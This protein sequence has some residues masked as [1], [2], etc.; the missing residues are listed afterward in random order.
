MTQSSLFYVLPRPGQFSHLKVYV[1]CALTH[2]TEEQ[3]A[4]VEA[5]KKFLRQFCTVLDFVG[6]TAGTSSDVYNYDIHECVKKCDL[7]IADCTQLS[8]GLGWELGTSVE[9]CKTRTMAVAQQGTK[10]T[11][12]VLG[13]AEVHPFVTFQYYVNLED[14]APSVFEAL[15]EL[16]Y[17][18][19]AENAQPEEQVVVDLGPLF[20]AFVAGVEGDNQ[21]W[22]LPLIAV[23]A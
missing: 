18:R 8:L 11:R 9:T 3:K 16:H 2:A 10:V 1:G 12:L 23:A 20:P 5:F 13:A 4:A 19:L 21:G 7:F 15:S 22:L 6:L 14:L 17:L